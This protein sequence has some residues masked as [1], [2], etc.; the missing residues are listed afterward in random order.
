M[1]GGVFFNSTSRGF[2]KSLLIL[3]GLRLHRNGHD[4]FIGIDGLEENRAI[5]VAQSVSCGRFLN[6]ITAMIS[7]A[8]CFFHASA[9]VG[10][11]LKDS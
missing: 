8:Y 7:P 3:I 11:H 10:M 4:R 6:P 5:P 2:G 1:E 9:L